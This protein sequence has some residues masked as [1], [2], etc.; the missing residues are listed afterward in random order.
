MRALLIPLVLAS[1]PACR[2]KVDAEGN[3]IEVARVRLRTFPTGA[4][5]WI[6]GEL[7]VESTPATLI[8]KP[9]RY[10]LRLQL[11]GAEA[12]TK[13]IEVSAGDV[14]ELEVKVP[15][16]TPSTLTVLSDVE[17]AKV[18]VNGYTRGYTPLIDA[19]T[20]P[21]TIDITL[22]DPVTHKARSLQTELAIGEKKVVEVFFSDVVS[23]ELPDAGPELPL[24]KP[25]AS[26]QLTLGLKPDGRVL[27]A[28]SGA[29]L[30]DSP[31][32]NHRIA[33]GT[34]ELILESLDGQ[35]R[36]TVEID[37]EEGK[38]TVYRFRLLDSDRVPGWAP[39]KD[40]G[41]RPDAR[42]TGRSP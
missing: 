7:K 17:G 13:P 34:H 26:G 12:I 41:P 42:P 30:G 39:A 4:R 22:T 33:A 23:A 40:A 5:A 36:R 14:T 18:R 38:T 35:Y 19:Q 9:G 27:D 15:V 32:V 6:D 8:L 20:K 10:E 24:S 31:L 21:G 16:P 25:P 11:E 29:R 37:V 28:D 1:L 2:A 3:P